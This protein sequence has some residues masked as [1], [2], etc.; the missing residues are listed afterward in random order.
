M[1]QAQIDTLATLFDQAIQTL[2]TEGA[3]PADWQNN[4]QI[5]R[6]KDVA[7][8]ILPVISPSLLQKLLRPIH[9]SLLKKSS[10]RC[11]RTKI[12]AK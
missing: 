10:M 8:V 3:L 9:V 4:S 12:F 7:T 1:S 5:T 11:L 2:Q 6:T